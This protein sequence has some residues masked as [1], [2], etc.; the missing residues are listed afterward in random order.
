MKKISCIFFVALLSALGYICS[1]ATIAYGSHSYELVEESVSFDGAVSAAASR[2]GFLMTAETAEEKAWVASMLQGK[3]GSYW[4]GA[5]SD[6]GR[7]TWLKTGVPVYDGLSGTGA[8]YAYGNDMAVAAKSTVMA[9]YIVEWADPIPVASVYYDDWVYSLYDE[10]MSQ[11]M[12]KNLAAPM[13][14]MLIYAEESVCDYLA[15]NLLP[16]GTM[17]GYWIAEDGKALYK[18][19][20]VKAAEGAQIGFITR[21]SSLLISSGAVYAGG[22]TFYRIDRPLSFHDAQAVCAYYGGHLATFDSP[23]QQ[24]VLRPL[25]ANAPYGTYRVGYEDARMPLSF[26]GVDGSFLEPIGLYF[27]HAYQPSNENAISNYLD[28]DIV[29][30]AMDDHP[31]YLNYENYVSRGFIMEIEA[32][33]TMDEVFL[34]GDKIYAKATKG[35]FYKAHALADQ[36]DG[37]IVALKDAFLTEKLKVEAEEYGFWLNEDQGGTEQKLYKAEAAVAADG[38]LEADIFI[39]YSAPKKSGYGG[40]I[41]DTFY[42]VFD[43]KL[44]YF[45]AKA[46]AEALGGKLMTVETEEDKALAEKLLQRKTASTYFIDSYTM[47]YA[48]EL[49]GNR[50]YSA[51]GAKGVE[52][53]SLVGAEGF[54]CEFQ[55]QSVFVETEG[56]FLD[57]E[58]IKV[59]YRIVNNRYYKAQSL[60]YTAVYDADG[61]LLMVSSQP[62]DAKFGI[63]TVQDTIPCSASQVKIKTMLL[64][65][66]ALLAPSALPTEP[67]QST[68]TTAQNHAVSTFSEGGILYL[69]DSNVSGTQSLSHVEY[70]VI[71]KDQSPE[72]ASVECYRV[73]KAELRGNTITKLFINAFMDYGDTLKEGTAYQMVVY[74]VPTSGGHITHMTIPFVYKN[75]HKEAE[76]ILLEAKARV[77]QW[78]GLSVNTAPE[79]RQAEF[80]ADAANARIEDSAVEALVTVKSRSQNMAVCDISLVISSS[81]A[82]EGMSYYMYGTEKRTDFYHVG[83]EAFTMKDVNVPISGVRVAGTDTKVV[84]DGTPKKYITLAFDDGITQD[85][86]IIEI[87]NRYGLKCCTFYIN[88]GLYGVDWTS[89]V[90]PVQ[91]GKEGVPH[92]RYTREQIETGI[93]D[94]FDVGVHAKTHANPISCTD[95]QLIAEVMDDWR[96]ITEL[97]GIQP[98][99][100]AWPGGHPAH[101]DHHIDVVNK[102]TSVKF[103]RCTNRANSFSLPE[104]FLEWL[105]TC[106]ISDPDSMALTQQFISAPCTEDMVLYLWGHG[107]EFDGFNSWQHLEN[108]IRVIAQAAEFNDDIVLV[109][110]SEFY[111][112]FK[113]EIP[114]WK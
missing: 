44:P 36:T 65:Q 96:E 106:G 76:K 58:G 57:N 63:T 46:Y 8:V 9:G 29:H 53:T 48:E 79:R 64:S 54:I 78:N 45:A 28:I 69:V 110:N 1:T 73:V 52:R 105:P 2:G 23:D 62:T 25:Y 19:G 91:F 70:A 74:G 30:G 112:L 80:I 56:C 51:I 114:S 100:M 26:Y 72:D 99:G 61:R 71:P 89:W 3:S 55:E 35:N 10:P 11:T 88:T 31:I 92:V 59:Q 75:Y 94:G 34:F 83:G 103:G 37:Q 77:N 102:Y 42:L 66:E 47:G 101:T 50:L 14:T 107:Y 12:A 38:R 22:S 90:G 49:I 17:N 27:W 84:R 33:P 43:T 95:D 82:T 39:S 32:E 5:N 21:T 60:V 87:L 13:D 108:M 98:V 81:V 86:R 111:Q 67:K 18:D 109:N 15:E 16:M 6:G 7:L 24:S 93:Y 85:A 20:T 4:L 113:D 40:K 97:T 68:Q 104:T 41:G